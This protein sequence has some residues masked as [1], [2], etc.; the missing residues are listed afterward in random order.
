MKI[1]LGALAVLLVLP[2]VFALLVLVWPDSDLDDAAQQTLAAQ[3]AQVD[4]QENLFNGLTGFGAPLNEE[5]FVAYGAHRVRE[6]NRRFALT[7]SS[8]NP[9]ADI[10]FTD[11]WPAS[12]ASTVSQDLCNPDENPCAGYWREQRAT[13]DELERRHRTHL[14]RLAH[15]HTLPG[16][17]MT[18]TPDYRAP[19]PRI[20]DFL[21]VYKLRLNILGAR[22][23]AADTRRAFDGITTEIAF[24]RRILHQTHHLLRKMVAAEQLRQALYVYAECADLAYREATTPDPV[25][26]LTAAEMSLREPYMTMFSEAVRQL[27]QLSMWSSSIPPGEDVA[28]WALR[29]LIKPNRSA[30]LAFATY[31]TLAAISELPPTRLQSETPHLLATLQVSW[32]EYL[33]N[34][35]GAILQRIATPTGARYMYRLH[36]VSGLIALLNAKL[37]LRKQNVTADGLHAA[38]AASAWR[39]PYDNGALSWDSATQMLS[40]ASPNGSSRANRLRHVLQ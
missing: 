35:V 27:T 34:P 11:V 13:L 9:G 28:D 17:A 25:T 10:D 15:L 36:D 30:N 29:P 19:L 24:A 33:I 37:E 5:D 20:S 22:C 39:N 3:P 12:G 16:Y 1:V 26:P 31:T 8:D 2:A 7:D 38:L 23:A 14:Q 4:E 21:A 40:F 32:Y 6:I 18:M